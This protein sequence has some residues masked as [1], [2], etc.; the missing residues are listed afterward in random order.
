[1]LRTVWKFAR[2]LFD[3][4]LPSLRRKQT[5]RNRPDHRGFYPRFEQL[6]QRRLLAIDPIGFESSTSTIVIQGTPHNDTAT[7]EVAPGGIQ[8]RVQTPD[9]TFQNVFP[10]STAKAVRFVG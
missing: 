5:S 3:V 1:M 2:H 4:P 10:G 9:G 6:E 8:V 7:V